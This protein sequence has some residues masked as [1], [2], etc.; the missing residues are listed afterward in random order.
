MSFSPAVNQ[1][2]LIGD[3]VYCVAAHPAAPQMP[4]SQTGR[5]AVVYQLVDKA[6]MYKALKVFSPH[7]RLPGLVPLAHQIESY[8]ALP[9]LQVC[10]R[11][12]LQAREHRGLLQE[13]PDLTYAVL[14]PWVE[15]DTWQPTH[16]LEVLTPEEL[17]QNLQEP[18][19]V[20]GELSADERQLL[21]R[22]TKY[23]L[24]ASPA[25]GVRRTAYLAE[26][27]WKRWQGGK[28]DEP[29]ALSPIYLHHKEPIPG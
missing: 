13:Y 14:M 21:K 1:S 23:A 2:L 12:V 29:A 25:Q 17:I 26:L 7:Y 15:G 24:L 5:Q 8:A 27:A 18:T 3:A 19:L 6:G 9:G 20:C 10:E 4:Y 16:D 28:T 22:E 11:I